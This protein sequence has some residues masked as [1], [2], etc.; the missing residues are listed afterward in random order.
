VW[1]GSK[2]WNLESEDDW[3]QGGAGD[4]KTL[5]GLRD[6]LVITLLQVLPFLFFSTKPSPSMRCDELRFFVVILHVNQVLH[7]SAYQSGF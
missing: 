7:F 4:R 2:S 5:E 6:K 1:G 3:G